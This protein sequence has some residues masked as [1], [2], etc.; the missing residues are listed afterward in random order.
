MASVLAPL[1]ITEFAPPKIRGRLVALYQLS[2]VI[3]ILLA[4]FSNWM[5]LSFSDGNEMAFGG[6]GGIHEIMVSQVW[7]G[8]FGSEMI[9]SG[10][11]ILLLFFIPESPRWLIKNQQSDKGFNI[12]EEIRGTIVAKAELAEIKETVNHVKGKISELFKPGLRLALIVGI[13]LSVFGQFTGVNI[14]VY[15]GPSILENAGFKFDSALQFQVAIGIINLIFTIIALWK[16]DSWGR[17]PLLIWG[18]LA[19]F[20]SLMIIATLFT[21]GSTSGIWIVIMLCIYMASLAISINAVIWVLIGEIFP[22]R[23]RGRAMSIARFANWGINSLTAFIFPWYVATI[24]MNAGF[25]TFAA[26]CLIATIFFY[27]YV[28]ETKGKSLEEIEKYWKN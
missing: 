22:N 1:Y 27:K 16:I 6:S 2:I 25:F 21:L 9:P 3:G 12:L 17:R 5:L 26:M 14:I 8:M 23:I 4:Y 15:Y 13:G 24:G 10:L 11:F 19:V 7:R 18:M 20:I 28:P